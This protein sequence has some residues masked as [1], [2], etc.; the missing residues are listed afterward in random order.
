MDG[1]CDASGAF[2][3]RGTVCRA[4][5]HGTC[6][7]P[8]VCTGTSSTCEDVVAPPG[9][10]CV[11]SF[12]DWVDGLEAAGACYSGDCVSVLE[13]C[14]GV[15]HGG[16]PA[17]SACSYSDCS[18]AKYASEPSLCPGTRGS[19]R[20]SWLNVWPRVGQGGF[21]VTSTCEFSDDMCQAK[22]PLVENSTSGPFA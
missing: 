12:D 18:R 17:S 19:P 8:D 21:N 10:D 15:V 7:P 2:K 22:G 9:T 13:R 16:L 3:A 4:S 5:E 6:D 14:E 11:D 20:W 1:C